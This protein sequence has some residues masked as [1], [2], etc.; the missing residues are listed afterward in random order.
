MQLTAKVCCCSPEIPHNETQKFMIIKRNFEKE[1]EEAKI[2]NEEA[3]K[4]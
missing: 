2:K 1:R 4:K 3:K